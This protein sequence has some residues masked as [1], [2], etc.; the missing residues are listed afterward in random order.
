[1]RSGAPT[2]P[3]SRCAATTSS[4]MVAASRSPRLSPCAPIGGMTC[5]ASPISSDPASGERARGLAIASGNIAAAGARLSSCRGSNGSGAR[6]RA[7][8]SRI[9]QRGEPRRFLRIGH[10]HQAGTPAGQ[11]H[12]RE[13]AGS[14]Y[15]IRL[16]CHGAS[17]AV[18]EIDRSTRSAD[19]ASARSRCRRRHGRASRRPSAPI[20]SRAAMVVAVI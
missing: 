2:S 8:I 19:R 15:E 20:A 14:R 1:M 4:A 6:S 11:R 5:A 10:E 17:A 13:R 3:P 9:G 16:K 18:A 12:E 7:A